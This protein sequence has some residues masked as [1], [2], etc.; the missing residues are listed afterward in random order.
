[1]RRRWLVAILLCILVPSAVAAYILIWQ[2]PP[3]VIMKANIGIF[4]YVWYNPDWSF[5]WD[6]AKIADKPVLDY[7]NSCDPTIIKQHLLEMQDLG[8]DF[9][10]I[11]WWGF[12]DD[13]GKFTD[14]AA[15]QVFETAQSINSTLKF[16][17]MVEPFNQTGNSY[18]YSGIYN[19]IYDNFVAPY[20][21]FYYNYSKPVI[22]F[23]NNQN[24]TDKGNIPLDEGARFNTILVGQQPYT[25]WIYTDLNPYDYREHGQNQISVTPRYDESHLPDRLGHVVVD[26]DLTQGVYD[27]EWENAIQLW[28][29]G[30]IDTILIST[31]NEY[32]ERTAIEPHIDATAINHDPYLLYNKTKDYINQIQQLAAASYLKSHFNE[33]VGLVYESEDKGIQNISGTNYSHDQIYYIYSDNLLATWALK[34][35]ET[36]ISNEI[37][38]TIQSN[39]IPPTMVLEHQP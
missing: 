6:P 39:N 8:I 27:R 23:F 16:A 29:D 10:I 1:M 34:P 37:N 26:S 30:K 9:V 14:N 2:P 17:I 36:Q 12:Y 28:K 5:S 21:S 24:L 32:P 13:Y 19:H 35:Y 18:D 7:Y 20:S 25:R 22:C 3:K 33:A 31:W 15:K 4:Y 11:S 38:Q